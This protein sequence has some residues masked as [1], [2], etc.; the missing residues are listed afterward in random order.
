MK[1]LYVWDGDDVPGVCGVA[2][3]LAESADD[4][5]EDITIG[6]VGSTL[7]LAV[8]EYDLDF[9]DFEPLAYVQSEVYPE[10]A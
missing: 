2:F 10:A 1:K 7:P 5:R 8:S 3:S 4:A 9:L 6:I